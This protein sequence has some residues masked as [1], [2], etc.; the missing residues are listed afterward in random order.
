M[1]FVIRIFGTIDSN[2]FYC[3]GPLVKTLTDVSENYHDDDTCKHNCYKNGN[4]FNH[5]PH[6]CTYYN[7]DPRIGKLLKKVQLK[8]SDYPSMSQD[9]SEETTKQLLEFADL[10]FILE[11]MELELELSLRSEEDISNM[12]LN[13]EQM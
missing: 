10:A 1:P 6:N 12:K 8:I 7:N 13:I 4:K 2:Y 9:E 5:V 11:D 3:S